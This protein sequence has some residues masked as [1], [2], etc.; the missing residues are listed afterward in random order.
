M[1]KLPFSELTI[2]NNGKASEETWRAHGFA[3]ITESWHL[4]YEHAM[5][6]HEQVFAPTFVESS[7]Q[8]VRGKTIFTRIAPV[9]YILVCSVRFN[10]D[11]GT[12]TIINI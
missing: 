12:P 7:L 6:F 8:T 3:E 4:Y 10:V 5:H 1:F 9:F 2:I 11:L